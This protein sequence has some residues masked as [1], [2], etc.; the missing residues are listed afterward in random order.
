MCISGLRRDKLFS[1]RRFDLTIVLLWRRHWLFYCA[2][3]VADTQMI[4]AGAINFGVTYMPG[5]RHPADGVNLISRVGFLL[6]QE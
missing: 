4:W 2:L 5:G 1:G 3:M 6:S